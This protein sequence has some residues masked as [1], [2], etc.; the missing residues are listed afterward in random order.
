MLGNG[1]S[2]DLLMCFWG[3]R[4]KDGRYVMRDASLFEGRRVDCTWNRG[5]PPGDGNVNRMGRT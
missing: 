4:S 2:S 5:S 1:P 3:E